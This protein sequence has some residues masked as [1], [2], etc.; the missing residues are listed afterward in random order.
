MKRYIIKAFHNDGDH[1]VITNNHGDK[2]FNESEMQ[3][4][5]NNCINSLEVVRLHTNGKPYKHPIII[6]KHNFIGR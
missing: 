5:V 2:V 1:T 4:I 6:S 3:S